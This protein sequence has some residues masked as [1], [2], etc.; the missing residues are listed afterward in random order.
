MEFWFSTTNSGQRYT[1]VFTYGDFGIGMD[2]IYGIDYIAAGGSGLWTNGNENLFDGRPHQVVLTYDGSSGVTYIDGQQV[3]SQAM[4]LNTSTTS[5]LV[6]GGWSSST[7]DEATVYPTAL[8]TAQVRAHWSRG[9]APTK[10]CAATPT[11][12]YAQSVLALRPTLYYRNDE[13][14]GSPIAYD[15]SGNCANAL[16]LGGAVPATGLLANDPDG[17]VSNTVQATSTALPTHAAPRSLEFWFASTNGGQRYTNVMTYGNYGIGM[18]ALY[19]VNFISDGGGGWTTGGINLFDGARH[20]IVTT[21]D[22]T[23]GDTYIDARLAGS[24]TVTANTTASTPLDIG[25]WGSA[26]FDEPAVYNFALSPAQIAAHASAGAAPG[27]KDG[28]LTKGELEGSGSAANLCFACYAKHFNFTLWPINAS[29]GNFWHTFDD[30]AVPGRGVALDMSHTYNSDLASTNGPL[31]YGWTFP[32]NMSLSVD[33][34]TGA[35][36]IVQENAA[37]ITFAVSGANYVAPTRSSATLVHNGDGT[38]TFTRNGTEV[39]RFDSS[40]QLLSLGDLDGYTTTVTHPNASTMVV[41]DP[42]GRT[43]T[44]A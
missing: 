26:T 14:S 22:G 40:G 5:P 44:L 27:F 3:L 4:S 12:S 19:G 11:S 31:G 8:S 24:W 13:A 1:N 18:D 15:S 7:S 38:W 28:P 39:I 16:H 30:L 29:T 10:P 9:V 37:T 35:A 34:E 25:G 42:A 32:Y 43:L 23:T 20:H 17:A 41:T 36:T 2:G 21:Y 6:I 33:G